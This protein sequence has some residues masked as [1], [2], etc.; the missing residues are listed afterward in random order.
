MKLFVVI[1]FLLF[2]SAHADTLTVNLPLRADTYGGTFTAFSPPDSAVG[3][4]VTSDDA[5]TPPMP[6][7]LFSSDL[8]AVWSVWNIEL[9]D[10]DYCGTVLHICELSDSTIDS[11]TLDCLDVDC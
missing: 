5:H 3:F 10:D 6:D 7:R 1:G 2:S 11:A 9:C 4:D 8:D